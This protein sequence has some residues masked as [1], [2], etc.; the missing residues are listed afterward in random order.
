MIATPSYS[1][2]IVINLDESIPYVDV[3]I[4]IVE[5]SEVTI[6]TETG[7][8]ND[9]GFIDS[10]IYLI[11]SVGD[12]IAAD[13]D[14]N[15]TETNV[16][17]SK[18]VT[19]LEAGVYTIRATS[20]NFVAFG[21]LPVGSYLLSS[22]FIVNEPEPTVTK[23]PSPDPTPSEVVPTDEPATPL[24]SPSQSE[25]E[26]IPAPVVGPVVPQ[27]QVPLL[28]LPVV[29]P[30]VMVVPVL[31]SA[32]PIPNNQMTFTPSPSF[33]FLPLPSRTP[34]VVRLSEPNA[35][36]IMQNLSFLPD[37]QLPSL[38]DVQE[39]FQE[40]SASIT[41]ALDS[42]PGGQ[43]VVAAAAYVGEQFTAAAEFTTNLGTE[44]T[45]EERKEAQQ[46]VLGAIIVTQLS[47]AT[48][49]IK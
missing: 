33:S 25:P 31:P 14:S 36:S 6:E 30:S 44:F 46:V 4:E 10:W 22:N 34:D 40:I 17:A 48:R 1:D 35:F 12:F 24:P 27:P 47:T 18:I 9:Y 15:H 29:E 45:P 28:P 32:L 3:P 26:Y 38:Q 7:T 41:A 21:G 13:D 20:W 49:R 43:Q 42:V 11:N 39:S 19:V 8:P 37:I 5:Q 23:E 2:D 16:L